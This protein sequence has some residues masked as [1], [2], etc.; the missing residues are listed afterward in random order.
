MFVFHWE[1]SRVFDSTG[2]NDFSQT[3]CLGTL[4]TNVLFALENEKVKLTCE[5]WSNHESIAEN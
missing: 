5:K 3:R 2:S 1:K 4:A